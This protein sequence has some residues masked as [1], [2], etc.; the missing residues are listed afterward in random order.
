VK[1]K[2]GNRLAAEAGGMKNA[3][4]RRAAPKATASG[5]ALHSQRPRIV[6]ELFVKNETTGGRASTKRGHSQTP[7]ANLQ[8]Q[9]NH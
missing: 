9:L 4:A 8:Q 1:E 5:T 3:Q 7:I 2:K 6:M